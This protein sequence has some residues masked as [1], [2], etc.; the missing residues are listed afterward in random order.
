MY[1]PIHR[2]RPTFKRS[3]CAKFLRSATT[4]V[5]PSLVSV[6]ERAGWLDRRLSLRES[7][8][9]ST[10]LSRSERR[11]KAFRNR[12]S[13]GPISSWG[14]WGGSATATP[15]DRGQR[16]HALVAYADRRTL[17][18]RDSLKGSGRASR[19]PFR[20]SSRPARAIVRLAPVVGRFARHQSRP[21][22]GR[23]TG[24]EPRRLRTKRTVYWVRCPH[25]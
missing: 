24:I 25:L 4:R 20:R 3:F 19:R 12:N 8:D 11:Q 15:T 14:S 9:Q 10:L 5:G 1:T 16:Q 17:L 13:L 18:R 2:R 23:S 21:N 7:S 22:C 6:A